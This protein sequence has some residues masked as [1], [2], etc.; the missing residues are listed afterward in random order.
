MRLLICA[1]I[2]LVPF[3][4][5]RLSLY[6]LLC[7]YDIDRHSHV[8]A[9]TLL[10]ARQVVM[11]GAR[12]GPLNILRLQRLHMADCAHIGKLNTISRV[13]GVTLDEHACIL[14]RNFIGGTFGTDVACGREDL[15]MGAWS[16]LSIGCFIDLSD[17]ITLGRHVV[18]AGARTQFWT[19]GF[20]HRRRRST[21][22]ISIADNVFV[23]SASVVVQ[24][25]EV[26][27][28]VVVAAGTVVH[29]SITEPGLYASGQLHRIR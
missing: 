29:R 28:D 20:D 10:L 25:V 13:Q 24:D 8:A 4:A 16:Q 15:T 23:G 5:L 22:P 14:N 19:H 17:C 7:G 27:A 3:N 2:A 12:I 21:G 6:R 11:R 26:C 9:G 18:V 1:L